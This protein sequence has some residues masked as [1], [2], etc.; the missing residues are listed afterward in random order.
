MEDNIIN[1][2]NENQNEGDKFLREE[3]KRTEVMP[4]EEK[5]KKKKKII[6]ILIVIGVLLIVT[7]ITLI[8]VFTLKKKKQTDDI[9]I[10]PPLIMNST[11]G[12][13]THTI[14][15]MPGFGNQ[16]EDFLNIFV[17]KTKFSKKNDTTIIILRSPY[18]Y[19]TR[20]HSKNYSWFDIYKNPLTDFSDLNITELKTTSVKVLEKVINNE[21]N[22][23]NGDY[24]KI[25]LGGHSQGAMISL[26]QAYTS[27]KIYGGVYA[28]SGI[29]PP[30]DIS[31]DKRKMKAWI[32]YGD[33]DDVISPSFINKTLSR[34][35]HFEGVEIHIYKDHT[36]YLKTKEAF[37]AAEFLDK[38]IK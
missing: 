7:A 15:F 33:I 23:L 38:I 5:I 11:S 35:A 13:H 4:D 17:N 31:D 36:H 9:Q 10:L 32:G 37:D 28:F 24:S 6:I 19:V 29:L 12:N 26:N 27:N 20:L 16:P 1:D 3:F 21:V 8:L 34:I 30:G 25:I 2:D 22:I 18:T 14:I